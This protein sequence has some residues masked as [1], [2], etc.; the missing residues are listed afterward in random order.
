MKIILTQLTFIA[1]LAFAEVPSSDLVGF[2]SVS[3][4]DVDTTTGGGKGKIVTVRTAKELQAAVE[5]SDIKKKADRE[6][7]PLV[8]RV[9]GD[10]DLG[11]LNNDIPGSVLEQVGRVLVGSN[12]TLEGASSDATIRH[13]IIE[14]HGGHNIIVRNLK[15]RDLWEEDPAG[16]YDRFGWDYVRISNSGKTHAHHVWIDHCDFEKA[17][18]GLLDITHGSDLITISWCRFAGDE[19]GPHKKAILIGHSSSENA[20]KVD[21]GYLNVTMHHCFFENIGDRAPRARFAN[22]HLFNNVV[23][24]AENATISVMN[25]AT[26]VENCVYRDCAIA[27]TFS[28]ASDTV[29]KQRGGRL[30][31]AGSLNLEPR[32]KPVI[33]SEREVFEIEHNFTSSCPASEFRFNDAAGW[34]WSDLSKVPYRYEPESAEAVVAQVRRLAGV[35]RVLK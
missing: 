33:D 23:D 1:S 14:V 22:I 12:T 7:V 5:R 24:G 11:E 9:E 35:E 17:Y 8:I 2:A 10:I 21:R 19:R 26:F 28:H 13:G 25:A 20:S 32:A 29:G 34:K 27:T 4:Y 30:L 16:K 6:K 3:A 31:I 15:F 18:D